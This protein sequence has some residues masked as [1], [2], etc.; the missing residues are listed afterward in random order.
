MAFTTNCDLF[1]SV[2]EAGINQIVRHVM[3]QRPSLFNYGTNAVL[4]NSR[5]L[6][7][8]IDAAPAVFQRN[9]PLLT[10]EPPLPI[11]ATNPPLGLDFVVQLTNAEV[12]FSPGNVIT[13]PGELNP[14]LANQR[15]ALH[16]QA[17]AGLGCPSDDSIQNYLHRHQLPDD[18]RL[19]A[20]GFN[21]PSGI[22]LR[23]PGTIPP[24]IQPPRGDIPPVIQ[25]P[26]GDVTVLPS[27]QLTCFCLDL[28]AIGHVTIA[29]PTGNERAFVDVDGLDIVEIKPDGLEDCLLC[30]LKLMLQLGILAGGFSIPELTQK[31]TS[32]LP[33]SIAI[34]PSNAVPNNPAVED[35][36]VKLF[37][38]V[39]PNIPPPTVVPCGPPGG[40][41]GGGGGG[42]GGGPTRSI[43]WGVGPTPP[44]GPEHLIVA[45]SANL[46]SS[47]FALVRNSFHPCFTPRGNFGP[48]TA[49]LAAGGH[50]ENGTVTLAND[51]TIT[52]TTIAIKWDTMI[53]DLD[54]DIPE[55][56]VGGFCIIGIPFDG[57]AVRAPKICVF[58][59]NPDFTI[60]LDLSGL[61][62]SRAT[63][64]VRPLTK[65][66]IETT[67]PGSMSDLDAEDSGIPN[68]W[69]V[70]L[71]PLF[72]NIEFLDIP[73]FVAT[74]LTNAVDAAVDNLLGF[75]PGWAKDLIKSILGGAISII[76][77]VL[78]IPGDIVT[79]LSNLIG[80]DL[81]L[82]DLV[83]TALAQHFAKDSPLLELEDPFP[84]MQAQA[85]P[86]P[87]IPVKIP[88]RDLAVQINSAEM[89]LQGKVGA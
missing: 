45:V 18:R 1:V 23:R 50:L 54:V 7:A 70:F 87:L 31:L 13:L 64:R 66:G 71:D 68:E 61:A 49:R 16:F 89:V 37:I 69:A 22:D 78:G 77:T 83:T 57:C 34:G 43:G 9:N 65:Y 41:G 62:T 5:L 14:P 4:Q 58:S 56:C 8:Q 67:R 11:F 29:G 30:Y 63:A 32:Q 42:G 81:N 60:P 86:F 3:R 26:R 27:S 72:V 40:S 88:I 75:L 80:V 46:V 82:F 6:C 2:N 48:F 20:S 25:P 36:Q 53:L 47:M 59:D 79:W 35:D 10:P 24:I 74:I 38:N 52:I 33:V 84:I 39:T 55:I 73:D 85:S 12:D 19:L 76:K 17:C 28:F 44:P 21:L 51:N 15:I